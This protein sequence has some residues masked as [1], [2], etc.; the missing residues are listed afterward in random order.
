MENSPNPIIKPII[1]HEK[2]AQKDVPPLGQNRKLLLSMTLVMVNMT[3][4]MDRNSVSAVLGDVKEYFQVKDTE[5]GLIRTMF[6]MTLTVSVIIFGYLGDRYNRLILMTFGL[7]VWATVVLTATLLPPSLF[8]IFVFLRMLVGVGEGSVST[9]APAMISDMY[10]G[11]S[12]TILFAIFNLMIP[13]GAGIGYVVYGLLGQ[14]FHRWQT[15]FYV[16]PIFS[17]AAIVILWTCITRD[18]PRG[19]AEG[20]AICLENK[21]SFLADLKHILKQKTFVLLSFGHTFQLFVVNCLLFWVPDFIQRSPVFS[22]K[23]WRDGDGAI[24]FGY[25]T[26]GGGLAGVCIGGLISAM[27]KRSE[28]KKDPPTSLAPDAYI[29]AASSLF[30]IPVL[31]GAIVCSEHQVS[32]TYALTFATVTIISTN[33]SVLMDASMYVIHPRCRALAVSVQLLITKAFGEAWSAYAIGAI[34]KTCESRWNSKFYSNFYCL[35]YALLT[36]CFVLVVG[37]VISL[38]ASWFIDDD[39]RAIDDMIRLEKQERESRQ[40]LRQYFLAPQEHDFQLHPAAAVAVTPMT[41]MTPLMPPRILGRPA[42]FDLPAD[43]PVEQSLNSPAN[44]GAITLGLLPKKNCSS[45]GD[46]TNYRIEDSPMYDRSTNRSRDFHSQET[47][48]DHTLNAIGTG[49]PF[50][51]LST[52]QVNQDFSSSETL[53]NRALNA[54]T[55]DGPINGFEASRRRSFSVE[56]RW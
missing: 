32:V 43:L 8:P 53:T 49:S 34:S 36:N 39:K 18:P 48:A 7:G 31:F 6:I 13:V 56:A 14:I 33:W 12:R 25:V 47:L 35:Q 15:G 23:G 55:A 50:V 45:G 40:N 37:G 4:Y 21:S 10:K 2:D 5:A 29:C 28:N 9:V 17:M 27:N 3:N 52:N 26:M 38:I 54:S 30:S 19:K 22:T 51:R 20:A 46:S 41:P 42:C 16:T 24:Y 44:P 11:K 1:L